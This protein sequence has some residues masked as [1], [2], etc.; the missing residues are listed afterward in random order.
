MASNKLPFI[1]NNIVALMCSL[2][3]LNGLVNA[4]RHLFGWV[5][6][7]RFMGERRIATHSCRPGIPLL[8]ILEIEH[9]LFAEKNEE[10]R[11]I[12]PGG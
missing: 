8:E 12:L 2:L 6:K 5:W 3:F 10:S 9:R 11:K 4:P 7:P 1:F